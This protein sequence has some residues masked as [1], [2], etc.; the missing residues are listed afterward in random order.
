M[1]DKFSWSRS[2]ATSREH[3]SVIET[4]VQLT[5]FYQ[6]IVPT[7]I[8][9][10]LFHMFLEEK[11]KGKN[12]KTLFISRFK[13]NFESHISN[14]LSYFWFPLMYWQKAEAGTQVQGRMKKDTDIQN[15]VSLFVVIILV[16]KKD[17]ATINN[18]GSPNKLRQEF[19]SVTECLGIEWDAQ[20]CET[21]IAV[22]HCIQL[23]YWQQCSSSLAHHL[24]Y[25][26]L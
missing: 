26:L 5:N 1:L 7:G 15:S 20:K 19:V 18:S 13:L 23:A 24:Q 6:L 3:V 17:K 22:W 10:I 11:K 9:P 8:L 4:I 21:L 14:M 25:H 2:T 16:N 12:P